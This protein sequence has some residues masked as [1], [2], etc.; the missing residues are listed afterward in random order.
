MLPDAPLPAGLALLLRLDL[1]AAAIE[2][3]LRFPW[4]LLPGAGLLTLC[5]LRARRLRAWLGRSRAEGGCDE[6]GL[7]VLELCC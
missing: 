1:D 3:L 2:P 5:R 4:R 7:E 6:I